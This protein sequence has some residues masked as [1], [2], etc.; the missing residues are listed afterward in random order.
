M[1]KKYIITGKVP[2]MPNI[3]RIYLESLIIFEHSGPKPDKILFGTVK[4]LPHLPHLPSC[5][6]SINSGRLLE[7]NLKKTKSKTN[8]D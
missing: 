3:E 6:T 8:T 1:Y 5:Q 2:K 4:D 7:D